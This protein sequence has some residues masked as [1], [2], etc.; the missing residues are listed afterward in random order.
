[1]KSYIKPEMMVESLVAETAIA[2][3]ELE[4]SVPDGW[5][6]NNNPSN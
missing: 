6:N 5:H 2:N 4:L 3:N 1:M